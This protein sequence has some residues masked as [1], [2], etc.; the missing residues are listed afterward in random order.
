MMM[1][2]MMQ[3][4]SLIFLINRITLPK[5]KKKTIKKMI[6]ILKKT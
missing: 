5:V 1:T 4:I 2:N 6:M 3:K